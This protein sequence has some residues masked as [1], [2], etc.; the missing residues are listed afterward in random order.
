MRRVVKHTNALTHAHIYAH[1]P[2]QTV[3]ICLYEELG[4]ARVWPA[5][6]LPE[7]ADNQL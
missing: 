2:K 4:S 1:R 7:K 5:A 6:K 3:Q